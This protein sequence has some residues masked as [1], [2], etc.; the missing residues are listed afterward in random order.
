LPFLTRERDPYKTTNGK[1]KRLTPKMVSFID[2]YMLHMNATKAVELSGYKTK[3]PK[4]MASDLLSHPLISREIEERLAKRSEKAE[5]KAE[6]LITKLMNIIEETQAD[7]PQACLRAIELAGKSIA[8]WKDRQEISGPD[9]KA[10]QQEQ[11]IKEN[12]ANF[13]SRV[14]SLAAR[15]GESNVIELSERRG[16]S[17]T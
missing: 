10:I 9:G 11:I 4:V 7:N 3:N 13:T 2:A 12:V 16:E 1:G 5:I 8:L 17:G 14:A 6:Y 15:A